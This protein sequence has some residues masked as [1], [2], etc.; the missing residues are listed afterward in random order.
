M[1]VLSHPGKSN[2]L[3]FDHFFVGTKKD[4]S[5]EIKQVYTIVYSRVLKIKSDKQVSGK[6]IA[7]VKNLE[8]NSNSPKSNAIKIGPATS[9]KKWI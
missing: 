6:E 4:Q 5:S 3:V 1:I 8:G 9:A 7:S 2:Q